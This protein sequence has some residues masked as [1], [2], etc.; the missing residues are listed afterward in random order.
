LA[1]ADFARI[2]DPA[3]DSNGDAFCDYK[4]ATQGHEG[5]RLKH[6]A[7]TWGHANATNLGILAIDTNGD[8]QCNFW[9]A[10]FTYGSA[11]EVRKC[12]TN[13]V[14]GRADISRVDDNT[15]SVVFSKAA[16]N[17]PA[18]YGWYFFNGNDRVRDAG[19][20]VHHLR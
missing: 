10:R 6:T 11:P 14:V 15:M 17:R 13:N 7:T 19:W 5:H 1:A 12:G 18:R 3:G 16:I 2:T 4:A 8:G 20:K 9:I